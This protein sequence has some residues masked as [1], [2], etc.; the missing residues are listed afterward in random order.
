MALPVCGILGG[1]FATQATVASIEGIANLS[2]LSCLKPNHFPKLQN[3][4]LDLY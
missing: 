4:A 2:S 1:S 3:V